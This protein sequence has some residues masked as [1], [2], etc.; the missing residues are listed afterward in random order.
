MDLDQTLLAKTLWG[1]L[2]PNTW[3][4]TIN[5]LPLGCALVGGSVRDCLLN[6]LTTKPD[7]DLIVPTNACEVTKHLASRFEGKYVVLDR[8]RD[9]SRLVLKGWTFDF[10]RQ[11]G[12]SIKEDLLRRDFTINAIALTLEDIPRIIDPFNGIQDLRDK[13]LVPVLLENLLD[14]PLRM[15][16]CFRFMSELDFSLDK[17]NN[18][19]IRSSSSLLKSV[20]NERIKFEIEKLIHGKSANK[21]IPILLELDLLGTWQ[22][23]EKAFNL[24]AINLENL[25]VFNQ[26]ELFKALPLVQLVSL[27]SDQGLIDL[28]FSKRMV[29]KCKFLRKWQARND[30]VAF[31][32]L[33]ERDRFQLHIELENELPALIIELSP[34]DQR[35]WLGRWR[36]HSDPLFHPSPPLDGNTLQKILKVPRGP[37]LGELIKHL[38]KEKAF[39]RLHSTEEAVQLARYLWKQKQ[40]FL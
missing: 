26:Q 23:R 14:D 38:C 7:L 9:I 16:R 21:V 28:G 10:A 8:E 39:D 15:L 30:G 11:S 24:G 13:K 6:Q 35:E 19:F 36:N 25:K 4:I 5:D 3:P 37:Y 27:L 33:N 2:D 12:E 1:R 34:E 32:T 40:P 31:K 17:K 18:E 22:N 29:Q 20:A